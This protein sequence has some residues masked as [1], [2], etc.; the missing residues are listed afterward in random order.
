MDDCSSQNNVPEVEDEIETSFIDSMSKSGSEESLQ[1]E[2]HNPNN[3]KMQNVRVMIRR[4]RVRCQ[5]VK[6][7]KMISIKYCGDDVPCV[8]DMK[9]P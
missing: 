9:R 5:S 3:P 8:E 6:K 7:P 2:P 1:P 4:L